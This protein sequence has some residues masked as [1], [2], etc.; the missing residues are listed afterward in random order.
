MERKKLSL[1]KIKV[2]KN[3]IKF[4]YKK[5]ILITGHTGFVGSWLTFYF[6]KLGC[7]VTGISSQNSNKN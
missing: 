6:L 1:E 5:K 4:F 2:D 3:L 7:K